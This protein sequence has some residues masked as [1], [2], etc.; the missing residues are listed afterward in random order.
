MNFELKVPPPLVM[1]AL[2]AIM[3]WV[4]RLLPSLTWHVP[5]GRASAAAVAA[6]GI[7]IALAGVLAFRANKTTVSPFSPDA[8]TTIVRS[9]IYRISR[10]PMYLGMLLVLAGWALYLANLAAL[11][12]VPFFIAYINAFQIS[13]EER[14][15]LAR[16][17]PAFAEYMRTTRRWI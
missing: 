5:G 7:A 2:G 9:G 13:P 10:N 15:L 11:V 14:I 3:Y 16:F 4:T 12:V 1:I 17:G 8:T 6:L